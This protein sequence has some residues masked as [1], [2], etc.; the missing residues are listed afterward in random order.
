MENIVSRHPGDVEL[1]NALDEIADRKTNQPMEI[2]RSLRGE[3][4]M[5]LAA[6]EAPATD[7][8]DSY[9]GEVD[10]EDP[11]AVSEA[12]KLKAELAPSGVPD[13]LRARAFRA[14]ALQPWI[15]HRTRQ[16]HRVQL[17]VASVSAEANRAAIRRRGSGG[18]S[19]PWG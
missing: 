18:S 14:R 11:N 13:D 12:N 3:I 8:M 6:A 4:I 10:P 16:G 15:E 7:L 19:R 9:F 17:A 1:L 2:L 5:S